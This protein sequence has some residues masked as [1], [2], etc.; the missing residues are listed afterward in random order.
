MSEQKHKTPKLITGE[1]KLKELIKSIIRQELEEM[2]G[3]GAAGGFSSP[4]AFSKKGQSHGK[5]ATDAMTSMGF[6]VAKEIDEEKSKLD[7]VGQEDDDVDNDGKSATKSDKY[8]LK[9]RLTISKKTGK[10]DTVKKIKKHLDD[11]EKLDEAVSRY[12]RFKTHPMK[13]RSKISMVVQEIT[14]MLREVDFLMTVNEK[15]K[16]ELNIPKDDLWKRTESR[17]AEIRSRLKSLESR[18]KT[19]H[20]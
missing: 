10:K 20:R 8:L 13:D 11:L 6:T 19:F 14:K 9:R 16:T 5:K 4:F 12:Q 7:P 2:T 17:I 15:L 3:T 18:L 1:D